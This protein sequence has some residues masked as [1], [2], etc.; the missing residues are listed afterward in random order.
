MDSAYSALKVTTISNFKTECLGHTK[1]FSCIMT[2]LGI[3]AYFTK[4]PMIPVVTTMVIF[5]LFNIVKLSYRLGA[6]LTHLKK[7]FKC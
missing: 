6:R 2:L 4:V 1:I 3:I 7:E 5:Y